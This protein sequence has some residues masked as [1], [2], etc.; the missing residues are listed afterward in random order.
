LG[1]IYLKSI[2]FLNS[3]ELL[4]MGIRKSEARAFL[5]HWKYTLRIPGRNCSGFSFGIIQGRDLG[6]VMVI[7]TIGVTGAYECQEKAKY[8]IKHFF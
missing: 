3:E 5:P 6:A 1:G 2:E 7:T 4:L 8:Y